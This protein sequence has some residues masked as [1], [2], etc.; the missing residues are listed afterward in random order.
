[1]KRAHLLAACLALVLPAAAEEKWIPLFNGKDLDGWT[2]KIKG[3]KLGDNHNDT[4]RVEDGAIKVSFDKYAKFGGEFGHLFY[5]SPFKSYRFRVEYRFTG[6]QCP[7]GPGWATRNSG[8]MIHCQD[9]A[10]MREDQDFPVSIE[11]QLLGGL[12]KGPRTTGNLCTPGTN[13]VMGGKLREEHCITSSSKTYDGDQ[14]V[15]A[16]IEVRGSHV[17]HIIEGATVLEYDDPQLDSRDR[18]AKA[19]I[20]L[21]NGEK[22][23]KGG[24]ISLQAESHPVE[25]RKV[26][27]L[28]LE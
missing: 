9:P 2:P 10:T 20:E 22:S 24:W 21:A 15:K 11:V 23:L 1:M 13:V 28:P 4:F 26:E 14:W 3:F 18:D 7:G 12:G 16:E 6:E 27:I 8:V 17:K 5:K 25:F 19:L